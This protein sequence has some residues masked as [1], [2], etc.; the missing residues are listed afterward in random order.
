VHERRPNEPLIERVLDVV[1]YA[2]VGLAVQ[3][4]TDMPRLVADGRA[5]LENRVKVA[6]WVGEMAVHVGSK[7]LQARL[8]PPVAAPATPAAVTVPEVP[9]QP[10]SQPFEGYDNLAAAQIVQLLG[11]LPHVELEMVRE[12]EAAG[13]HRRTILAKIEQL[14]AT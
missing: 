10:L 11:R 1:L 8:H 13:R 6:R 12:Y 5:Q 3:L 9:A 14:L 2:P 7:Q 4:R